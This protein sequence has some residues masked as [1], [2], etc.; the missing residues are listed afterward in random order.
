[1]TSKSNLTRRRSKELWI[2]LPLFG[3]LIFVALYVTATYFYP[4][5]SQFDHQSAGFSWMQNYWCNL[6]NDTAING[7]AN[8]A[9]PIASAGMA[10]LCVSLSLFWIIFPRFLDAGK[11][12]GP[13]IS[14]SGILAMFSATLLLSAYDHDAITNLASAFG[15]LALMG[16]LF[17]LYRNGWHALFRFGI[18]NL[19]LVGLNNI[20]YYNPRLI[21]YLPVVQKISFSA[22][23]LWICCIDMAM[24]SRWK[25]ESSGRLSGGWE[26]RGC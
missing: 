12:A 19:L 26:V 4:G 13:M 7:Q 25:K 5:G 18:V 1:M 23:L 11:Y 22:I 24:Y 8:H 16:T 2:L 9:K 6:L 3:I 14:I 17:V 15:V 10:V 20:L 21:V